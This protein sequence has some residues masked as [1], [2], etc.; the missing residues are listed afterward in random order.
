[1]SEQAEAPEEAEPWRGLR[2]RWAG[3][4]T[5]AGAVAGLLVA[6]LVT[7]LT[8]VLPPVMTWLMCGALAWAFVAAA[9][10]FVLRKCLPGISPRSWVLA[11]TVGGFMGG[12]LLVVYAA[13]D[14]FL[15]S[16]TAS[17]CLGGVAAFFAGMVIGLAQWWVINEHVD[18]AAPWMSAAP[19]SITLGYMA[20][21]YAGWGMVPTLFAWNSF[22]AIFLAIACT[23][24]VNGILTAFALVRMLK[25]KGVSSTG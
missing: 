3:A 19:V 13:S 8:P 17:A 7:L 12:W 1:M 18:N 24:A 14:P 15:R 23:F 25:Q 4:T 5:G 9:Q 11:N 6:A 20:G 16:G 21:L 10:S 22:V 2:L